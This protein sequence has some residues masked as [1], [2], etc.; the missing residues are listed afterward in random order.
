M[1]AGGTE[2]NVR[3]SSGTYTARG[4]GKSASCTADGDHAVI[5]LARK[6]G[7]PRYRVVKELRLDPYHTRLW[8]KPERH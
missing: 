4:G 7:W 1:N 8:I 2:I 6:L 3:Y 5:G